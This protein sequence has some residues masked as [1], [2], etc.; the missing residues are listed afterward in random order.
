[1]PRVLTD[2]DIDPAHIERIIVTHHHVDHCGLA[3]LLAERSGAKIMVHAK[4]RRF[5]EEGASPQERKWFGDF[6]A[7]RLKTHHLEYL[8]QPDEERLVTI[9]GIDFPV[10]AES[11]EVGGPGTLHI[12]GCPDLVPTHT[13]DQL[14][15]LYS[16][17]SAPFQ[18][19][20][21]RGDPLPTHDML[22]S[23]DLWLM[24]GP[25]RGLGIENVHRRLK[26]RLARMLTQD[27]RTDHREQDATAKDALKRGF[28]LVRVKPGH[29]EEFIGTRIIPRGLLAD[30]DILVELGYPSSADRSLL[31][32]NGITAR[33]GAIKEKAYSDFI[34][35]LR[36]WQ[37]LGYTQEDIGG[38]LTRIY[39]EQ[40][41]GNGDVK[42]DRNQR[43]KRLVDILARLKE[44]GAKESGVRQL[45]AFALTQLR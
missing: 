13:P 14:L 3:D 41:G 39:R 31:R 28:C 20:H 35:E 30:R 38:L 5:V 1:M 12:L 36:V 8:A 42:K 6:Q 7:S 25:S 16:E 23:G 33:V 26:L 17:R 29:G 32:R 4:F 9:A 27:R 15:V 11:I 40:S 34:D 22:F 43:R 2:N 45:A 18:H 37:E 21:K 10:L 44:D 19:E 24:Q